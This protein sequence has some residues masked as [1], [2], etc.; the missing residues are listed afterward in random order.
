M[1]WINEESEALTPLPN[2]IYSFTWNMREWSN[3]VK[4]VAFALRRRL[5]SLCFTPINNSIRF[6]HFLCWFS[7][8]SLRTACL[9]LINKVHFMRALAAL[10]LFINLNEVYCFPYVKFKLNSQFILP[11]PLH[12][13][14]LP[15]W[16]EFKL[17]CLK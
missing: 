17:N 14:T 10:I 12:F 9:H 16:M 3:E 2:A 1:K 15:E 4:W 7:V 11:F 13:I 8:R 6:T 5:R